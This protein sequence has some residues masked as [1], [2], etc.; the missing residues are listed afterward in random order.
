MI[1]K[2]IIDPETGK[3]IWV[4]V[5]AEG[6]IVEKNVAPPEG[7]LTDEQK[8]IA[9]ENEAAK[10]KEELDSLKKLYAINAE[11]TASNMKSLMDLVKKL[12]EEKN[13]NEDKKRAE[14]L[15]KEEKI[16]YMENP[17]TSQINKALLE[18]V[19]I[20]QKAK[21]ESD[22]EKFIQAQLKA[23][24]YMAELVKRL[25]IKTQADYIKIIMPLEEME[26]EKARMIEQL[27]NNQTRNIYDEYGAGRGDKMSSAEERILKEAEEDAS[28]FLF[29]LIN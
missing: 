21:E 14:D 6:N 5:D 15:L 17:E 1:K 12:T 22:H 26:E 27:K 3:E 13:T 8:K 28:S 4:L 16:V 23:K 18:K 11:E 29:R 2:K 9:K 25:E 10:I 20:L 7:E 19:S 24:P